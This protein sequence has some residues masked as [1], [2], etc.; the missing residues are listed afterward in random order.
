MKQLYIKTLKLI[1]LLL[2]ISVAGVQAQALLSGKVSD[3]EST[4]TGVSVSVSGVG[5]TITNVDGKYSVKLAKGNYTVTFSYIGY[6][7]LTK[8][9]TIIDADV[10]LDVVLVSEASALNEVVVIGG[11]GAGRTKMESAVP[12]DVVYTNQA[13]QTT[14]KPDLMSQL[15]QAVPS[16]N[17]NKQSGGDGTDAIDFASLRGLGFDQTL[18][19]VNGKRRHLSAFVN[20]VGTRGRGNS[21]TDLNAIPEA[22]IDHVEILRDGASAQYGSDAIAGVINIVLKKDINHLNVTG[23]FSGY[24]D[25]KY[26]TLNNVDPYGYYTGSKF[27]GKTVNIGA[28][29]GIAIGKNGGFLNIGA[30]YEN[31]GKTFRAIRDTNWQT[32]PNTLEAQP[33]ARERRAFGDGSV[34]SGGGMYNMEI[35][36]K[37]TKTTFYS[38]G[39][40]NY[41]HSNVYAY[42]RSWNYDNGLRS[43]PTKFPT[44]ANGNLVFV[45]G[46]MKVDA[47]PGTPYDPNNVYY[48]PQEDVYIKDLSAAVGFRGTTE[49][50]WDWD[51]SNNLG[52]NDFH[53][54]GNNTF[55]ASLPYVPGQ[56]IQ[57]RFDDGGFNFLQN[58][59]NADITKRIKGIGQGLQLSF[60]GEFRYERYQLYAGEL[61]SYL[62]GSAT[63]PD[64]TTK[65]SGS[66]GYP[67]YQP[68]DASIAHRTNEA[69]YAEGALDVTKDWLVDGAARVENYSDFGGVSTFKLATRYK[70]AGNFNVRGSISTGFRAPSLQQLN[71]SNT[72]TTV[73]GGNLVYTKLVPNYSEVARTAGIP[74]LK[75]E[76]ST[77]YSLG[78]TWQPVPELAVTVDAYEIKVKNRIVISGLYAQGDSALGSRLNSILASQGIGDAQFFANAVNTTNKGI[79]FVIDYKKRWESSHFTALL[80]GNIQGLT[81]DKINI[82]S[83]FKGSAYDSA[84]FF[85]D[86]EQYFLKASA[87][88]AKF[89]L[90]LEYGVKKLS[91]GTRFTYYGDV[92]ELG[93]GETSAPANAPDPFFP[94]VAL[95]ATGAPV[96]EIFDFSPKVT[97]DLYASLKL[98]K[99]VL[100]TVG[101]D[102]LFNV[103]PDT[104]VIKGSVNPLTGS[105]FGDSESG[106]PFEAV[107]MGFNG[108]RIFTKL[109]LNF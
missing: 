102:N 10:V 49:S 86:R 48:D 57:T 76:T 99:T 54:W 47:A 75:Q 33:V 74:K 20:E 87:P 15:N 1:V 105:S 98:N 14:A 72:N 81:I 44:D 79:D 2:L 70:L 65:A 84:T 18:V 109:T 94:Y 23:G 39:G 71:F 52:R 19:L 36:I 24:D 69:L 7:K 55:N 64:G 30:N 93:F 96:P 40:Y 89:T 61:N 92:K 108:M 17:Y 77:N 50:G 80:A 63:L 12:V 8:Q 5:G 38:F 4:L 16:F 104:N 37:G 53:Y 11:R 32:N 41:K 13:N 34:V 66:E 43:N 21:G 95:D 67:G 58:T 107:Q 6:Q 29:Y 22:S 3:K 62:Q 28:D 91:F 85:S 100:W 9:V 59:A 83:T 78:F 73:I 27:D 68:S 35:P 31:Q 103:H 101:V 88:K 106:G 97:T 51:I 82:P 60:G 42:T 46:I 25:Q 26:N 90:N 45:P 56:P